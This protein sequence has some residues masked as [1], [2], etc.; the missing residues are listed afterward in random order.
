VA[1]GRAE[2]RE[3]LAGQVTAWAGAE[4]AETVIASL[5]AAREGGHAARNTAVGLAGWF[6]ALTVLFGELQNSLNVIW[7]VRRGQDWHWTGLVMPRV[8]SFALVLVLGALIFLSVA[9]G[10]ALS[11][12]QRLVEGWLHVPADVFQAADWLLSFAMMTLLFSVIYKYLP[13][14]EICWRDTWLGAAITSVLFTIGRRAIA[15]YLGVATPASVYGASGSLALLLLWVYYSSQV[16][17]L[18][19]EFTAAYAR[20]R[21]G[22]IRPRRKATFISES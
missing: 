20:H 13:D 15:T 12:A 1:I 4:V 9:A 21:G 14:A 6:L 11:G 19:A 18:G 16:F 8:L 10:V 7:R 22:G 17:F 3:V 2:A 5:R